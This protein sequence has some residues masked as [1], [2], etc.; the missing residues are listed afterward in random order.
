MLY[1]KCRKHKEV[2]INVCNMCLVAL[3][4]LDMCPFG[5]VEQQKNQKSKVDKQVKISE[6]GFLYL[7]PQ[8]FGESNYLE[9]FILKQIEERGRMDRW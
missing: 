2:K 3:L 5:C 4:N 1:P 7:Y 6:T 9:V 8:K